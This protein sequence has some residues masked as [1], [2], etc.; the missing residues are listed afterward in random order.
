MLERLANERTEPVLTI[1]DW[2]EAHDF[3]TLRGEE[4]EIQDGID[5]WST[6]SGNA[7]LEQLRLTLE[8]IRRRQQT[9]LGRK[10]LA[11]LSGE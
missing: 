9:E 4:F 11:Q 6:F 8:V 2:A 5:A 7:T 10:R 3:P 1:G